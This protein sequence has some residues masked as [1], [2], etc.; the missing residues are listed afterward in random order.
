MK[1]KSEIDIDLGQEA[2][3]QVLDDSDKLAKWQPQLAVTEQRKPNFIAGI[4]TTRWS[5]AVVVYH[6]EPQG[7]DRTKCIVHGNHQ[8]K[9]LKKLA[10]VF[11]RQTILNQTEADLERL[12]LIA[13]T[14]NNGN[15]Q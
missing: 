10:S 9:G 7:K 5:E 4:C 8:F 15:R 2:L 6:L 1:V 3:W 11:V 14:G 13:E 12:K